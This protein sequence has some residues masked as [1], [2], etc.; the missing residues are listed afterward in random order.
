LTKKSDGEAQDHDVWSV[1][2]QLKGLSTGERAAL[3]RMYLTR[4][5]EAEGVVEKIIRRAGVVLE[6]SN[7]QAFESWKLVVHSAALI[8]GTSARMAHASHRPFGRALSIVGLKASSVNRLLTARGSG[9]PDQVRHI[10]YLLARD[11]DA[12]PVNMG[13][14]RDLVHPDPKIADNARRSIA[15]AYYAAEDKK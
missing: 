8:A 10:S 15:R 3:R 13:E 2:D 5:F 12:I 6:Y 1:C 11:T 4:S 9:L 7:M 14:L